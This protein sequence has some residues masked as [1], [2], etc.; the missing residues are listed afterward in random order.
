MTND[1][2]VLMRIEARIIPADWAAAVYVYKWEKLVAV[3]VKSVSPTDMDREAASVE[4]IL[5]AQ[6]DSTNNLVVEFADYDDGY[7]AGLTAVSMLAQRG[8]MFKN[9]G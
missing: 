6:F 2:R 5:A 9:L 1:E 4:A 8:Y 3:L 7:D